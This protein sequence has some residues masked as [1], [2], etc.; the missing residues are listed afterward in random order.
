[1]QADACDEARHFALIVPRLALQEPMILNG[2][3]ALASKYD[4]LSNGRTSDLETTR[5]HGKCI[6][7]LIEAF[8]RPPNT[9]LLVAVVIS[10]L[11]EE[12]DNDLDVEY[13]HLRGTKSLLDHESVARYAAEGGLAEAASWVHLRQAIYVSLTMQRP[14]E[15]SLHTFE[16]FSVVRRKDDSAYA[17]RVVLILAKILRHLCGSQT[18]SHQDSSDLEPDAP[19]QLLR[20]E[21]DTWFANKPVTFEPIFQGD[22]ADA[23]NESFP[24]IWLLLTVPGKEHCFP[25]P[26]S[27]S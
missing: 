18:G 4:A 8:D 2:L 10:R 3:L 11:Y 16:S 9:S 25:T 12:Y 19:L 13:Y 5:Y 21:L 6:E 14:L 17:N 27:M 24:S 20:E 23:K 1:M 15:I 7:L 22:V 26:I